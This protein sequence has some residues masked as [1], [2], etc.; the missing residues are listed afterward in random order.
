MHHPMTRGTVGEIKVLEA[1]RVSK[2]LVPVGRHFIQS[3]HTICP[4]N[5]KRRKLWH[6]LFR[7]CHDF[8]DQPLLECRIEWISCRIIHYLQQD[9]YS[10]ASEEDKTIDL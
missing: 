6:T 7:T 4:V 2:K 3:C 8:F 9:D 10:I 1:W 5:S